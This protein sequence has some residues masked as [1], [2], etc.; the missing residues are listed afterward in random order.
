MEIKFKPIG[1]IHSPY[2]RMEET[3]RQGSFSPENYSS[4]EIFPQY[5]KGLNDIKNFSHIIVIYFLHRSKGYSL[6]SK[7]QRHNELRG[8]FTTR[9]P[10]RPNP[11][12]FSAV[13]LL[14]KKKGILTVSGLDALDD[15]PV[16]D[17]KPYITE[18]DSPFKNSVV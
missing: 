2:Q 5:E 17:I 18:K 7:P 16:L 15:T 3:P 6:L 4:I 1:I 13:K 9:S 10:H 12:G 8:V 11:I 14:E